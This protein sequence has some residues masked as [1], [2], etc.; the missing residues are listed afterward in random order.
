MLKSLSLKNKIF[1]ILNWKNYVLFSRRRRYLNRND[2]ARKFT[3]RTIAVV[4]NARAL[5]GGTSGPEIDS[6]DVVLRFNDCPCVS[7]P[8]HGKRTDWIALGG[9]ISKA[10][11]LQLGRPGILWMT[12]Q[13]KMMRAWYISLERLYLH[14]WDATQ[15]AY[16]RAGRRPSTGLMAILLLKDFDIAGMTLFGFDFYRSR[17]LSGEHTTETT[18]HNYV[19]EQEIIL[20][21]IRSN[22]L[23]RL[24]PLP[25]ADEFSSEAIATERRL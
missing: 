22:P 7:E 3:G 11:Y 18:P 24:A 21:I 2:L 8:S 13:R 6:H 12:P 17:S 1:E 5:R 16:P 4:G 25:P 20:D 15:R 9:R 23:I 19:N 10:R 14:P